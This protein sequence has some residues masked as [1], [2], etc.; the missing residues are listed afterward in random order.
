MS[1]GD[2]MERNELLE[3]IIQVYAP[4]YDIER[5][6]EAEDGLLVKAVFHEHG[7]GYLLVKKA[8]LWTAD[9]HEYV[10]IFS[11][12]ELT[13]TYFQEGLKRVRAEGEPLVKPAQGHMSTDLVAMFICDEAEEAAL[14]AAKKSRIRKSFQFSLKGWMEVQ[15]VI[16]E[17]R[18]ASVTGNIYAGNTAKFL[19]N[20]LQ[21]KPERKKARL[22]KIK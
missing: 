6:D 4:Y 17:V 7:T 21:P 2:R 19:K 14:T 11:V 5:F 16:A 12:P 1:Q 20:L 9:R 15:T 10:W 13:E 8:E 3:K 18:R 22:F